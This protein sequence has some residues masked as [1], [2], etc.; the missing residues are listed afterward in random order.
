MAHAMTPETSKV[1]ITRFS[2]V[3]YAVAASGGNPG[4]SANELN[5]RVPTGAT[6]NTGGKKR[7]HLRIV[8]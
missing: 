7:P 2:G 6:D 3:A 5:F 4:S 1:I 8:P